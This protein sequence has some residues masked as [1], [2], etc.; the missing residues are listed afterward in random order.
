[1]PELPEVEN[2]KRNIEPYIL[3]KPGFLNH[4]TSGIKLFGGKETEIKLELKECRFEKI[5]RIGKHLLL[6]L[7]TKKILYIHLGMSGQLYVKNLNYQEPKHSHLV[8]IF[9]QVKLIYRDVRRFGKIDLI[10][11]EELRNYN[12]LNIAR[13]ALEIELTEFKLNLQKR[14]KQLIKPSLLNQKII[15]GVGNIYADETLFLSGIHPKIRN[16][17][18]TNK[19]LTVLL[20]NIKKVL[21]DSINAK[22][23]SVTYAVG[24]EDHTGSYQEQLKVYRRNEQPCVK[25]GTKIKKIVVAQRG[26]HFCP[27]CQNQ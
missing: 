15:A 19:Q 3:N 2:V 5:N 9:D 7:N 17:E 12:R 6:Y 27:K 11:P 25:C 14:K 21:Q 1:M 20:T 22:G 26:T 23:S 18:L 16:G 4:I 13:D 10:K 8:L 24:G